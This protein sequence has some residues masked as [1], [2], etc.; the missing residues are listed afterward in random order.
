[1]SGWL[2]FLSI[3]KQHGGLQW[4]LLLLLMLQAY[5]PQLLLVQGAQ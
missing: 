3:Q 1:M 4:L 2:L 5:V